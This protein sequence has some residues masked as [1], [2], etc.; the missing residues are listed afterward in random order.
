MVED[1]DYDDDDLLL[2][3]DDELPDLEDDDGGCVDCEDGVY[4]GH[5][6]AGHYCESCGYRP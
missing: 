6:E 4:T 1:E 2:L 5:D 3:E